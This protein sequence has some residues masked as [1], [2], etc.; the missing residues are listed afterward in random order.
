[1]RRPRV[2]V[3]DD[4][5]F[6]CDLVT[7]HIE[8]DV[9]VQIAHT[10]AEATALIAAAAPPDLLVV[11]QQ[12]P[13]G[14]GLELIPE[15]H[16]IND[17]AKAIVVTGF[18]SLDSA[19]KAI[20]DGVYDYL[21]KP[22]ALEDLR[23]TIANGLR[24]IELERVEQVAHYR[25]AADEAD[26]AMVGVSAAWRAVIAAAVQAAESDAPVLITGESGSGKTLVARAIH[27]R[28]ARRREAFLS[29]NC[30]ALPES[31][32]EA[33]LFGVE[34]GAYTGANTTRKGLFELADGGTLL[35]DELGE[36]SLASQ[37]KL[38]GTVEDGLV[39]RLGGSHVHRTDVRLLS[40]TNVAPA[41]AI[42][43]HRLR[44]DLY[45][46]LAVLHI[47]MPPLAS[48]LEDLPALCQ[49]LLGKLAPGRAVHLAAGEIE[50]LQAYRWAGNVR[51]LRNVLER[52][53]LVDR[54]EELRPSALLDRGAARNAPALATIHAPLAVSAAAPRTL[55]AME[56]E[57]L[58]RVFAAKAGNL[59]HTAAALDISLST[60]RSKLRALGVPPGTVHRNPASAGIHAPE[61][62][63]SG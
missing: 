56:T 37:A 31:L 59:T 51:E 22:F 1:M 24:R 6:F 52:A 9:D 48:R 57:H 27:Y 41:E 54:G 34:R 19:V 46:R 7:R 16:R 40:A 53:L 12:L 5:A 13:D 32:A 38:L 45:Y 10:R 60:L 26:L 55:A 11:D 23:R 44:R 29:I 3:V 58:L 49:Y 33:E 2:L 28:S 43:Q 42:A 62:G 47:E 4:D 36:L 15:L 8:L 20:K 39:R 35:L 30:G 63:E 14:S 61:I 17:N 50:A 21:T 18:P 25:R